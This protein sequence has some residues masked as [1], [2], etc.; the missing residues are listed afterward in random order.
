MKLLEK[1]RIEVPIYAMD[2]DIFLGK[3]EDL[4]AYI[5][6]CHKVEIT[7]QADYLKNLGGI[8]INLE[9]HYGVGGHLVIAV[10]RFWSYSLSY[11]LPVLMHEIIHATNMLIGNR[12]MTCDQ[13]DDENLTYISSFI[14]DKFLQKIDIDSL[15]SPKNSK[16]I[17]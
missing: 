16:N 6:R 13:D 12:G 10:D 8:A 7:E 14:F 9:K 1:I 11:I 5:K 3:I 15:E 17:V 4:P 2:I